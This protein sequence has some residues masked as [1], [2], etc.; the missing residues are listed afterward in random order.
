MAT[1]EFQHIESI[2]K[3][4]YSPAIVNQIYMKSPVWS[5]VKKTSKGV[6]GKRVYIPLRHTL[7]EAVGGLAANEY[8]LPAASRVQYTHTYIYQKRNYGRV[9]VDGLAIEAGK[10]KGGWIDAFSG[11]TKGVA[12]AFAIDVDQQVMGRGTGILGVVD[13]AVTTSTPT[14]GMNDPHGITEATPA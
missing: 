2:L 8:T 13:T 5:Q 7:S 11:E 4:W 14:I 12:D 9:Q 1:Q 3:E 6:Q 10:G